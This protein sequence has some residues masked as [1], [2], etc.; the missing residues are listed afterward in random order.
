MEGGSCGFELT[1][2]AR[3]LLK[4]K[5]EEYQRCHCPPGGVSG[6]YDVGDAV[7]GGELLVNILSDG[8]GY[9]LGAGQESGMCFHFEV[10]PLF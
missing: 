1:L 7:V 8:R 3:V 5:V 9:G 2:R 6:E 10:L 4:G